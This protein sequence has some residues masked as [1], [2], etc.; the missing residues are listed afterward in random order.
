MC[1][2]LYFEGECFLWWS[3]IIWL[4][5]CYNFV[6][7]N[8]YTG[9]YQSI[10]PMT[11][12]SIFIKNTTPNALLNCKHR[13]QQ[14]DG[15]ALQYVRFTRIDLHSSKEGI[16]WFPLT[17]LYPYRAVKEKRRQNH[18]SSM[19]NP[20]LR[21]TIRFRWIMSKLMIRRS[22]R[23]AIRYRQ[24]S[25]MLLLLLLPVSRERP[26][27]PKPIFPVG[28]D[29]IRLH[30][31]E[32]VRR[33]SHVLE[34]WQRFESFYYLA[35]Q[36]PG[37]WVPAKA[38]GRQLC[39]LLSPFNGEMTFKSRVYQ[40]VKPSS[41]AKVRPGPLHKVMLPIRPV[42]VHWSSTCEHLEKDNTKAIYIGFGCKMSCNTKWP[43]RIRKDL[44]SI[45]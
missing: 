17:K 29:P 3:K 21:F 27:C 25:R 7:W 22:M 39:S 10:S 42:L 30:R 14:G 26:V 35:H 24:A 19:D 41:L 16:T 2:Y 15:V 4:S 5:S 32:V 9:L 12:L 40:A 34:V 43:N 31:L 33:A 6:K 28:A 20:I 8:S 1:W 13:V 44:Y 45:C 11:Y 23:P 18:W 38:S 37:F 36:R